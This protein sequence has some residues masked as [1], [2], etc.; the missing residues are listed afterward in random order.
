RRAAALT[1]RSTS[2]TSCLIRR[3]RARCGRSCLL[4]G[5]AGF[6]PRRLRPCAPAEVLVLFCGGIHVP[7]RPSTWPHG[8][9][10]SRSGAEESP[11]VSDRRGRRRRAAR[12]PV[13]VAAR[14]RPQ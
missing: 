7:C 14:V 2:Y 5:A 12:V 9:K 8:R 4:P 13:V 6:L 11:T 3:G 10:N 1:L